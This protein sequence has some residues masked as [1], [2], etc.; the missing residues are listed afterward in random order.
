V[1]YNIA[2][3][4]RSFRDAL[5]AFATGVTIVTTRTESGEDIGLTANSFNSVSLNPP[6]VLWSLARSSKNLGA[7]LHN[8]HFAVHVL[9]SSQK[10]LSQRF[11]SP[12]AV[13]FAGLTLERGH[14]DVPLLEGCSAR[15]QC[16]TAFRREG[17][18][19]LI[20]VGDVLAFDAYPRAPLVFHDG[21]YAHAVGH[22]KSTT[23]T[24]SDQN[25]PDSSFS[26]DFL[27]YL[28]GRAR[29]NLL[30]GLREDLDR[31]VLVE[32]ELF[33][34]SLL[35][36]SDNRTIA[37]LDELLWH[38]GIRVT[39]SLVA[40]IAAAGYLLVEGVHDPYARVTLT[41]AGRR[42]VV[43]LIAAAKAVETHAERNLGVGE[44]QM[45]KDILRSI[46]RDSEPQPVF[47]LPLSADD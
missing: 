5:S 22:F 6:M 44:T 20:F 40:R 47:K 18:D 8:P 15:F 31:H 13:K 12:S 3:D 33:V 14:G 23:E 29:F 41:E 27:V 19:H 46:I 10:D 11:A 38:T 39:F 24:K 21:R 28:L 34:L 1:S 42:V 43:E 25:E 32:N 35:G 26:H 2:N 16:R 17:G 36:V 7:F 4:S 45:L 37:E 30:L 9:A